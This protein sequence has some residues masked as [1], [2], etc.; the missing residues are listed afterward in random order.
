L[1]EPDGRVREKD[2]DVYIVSK[3]PCQKRGGGKK[4][5]ARNQQYASQKRGS[6]KGRE[7][8][9]SPAIQRA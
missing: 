8:R 3:R 7:E 9:Y 5:G 6:P 2:D 1:M 4:G